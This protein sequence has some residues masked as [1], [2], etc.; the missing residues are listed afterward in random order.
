MKKDKLSL[1]GLEKKKTGIHMIMIYPPI[2][3]CCRADND[4]LCSLFVKSCNLICRRG[5]LDMISE[6]LSNFKRKGWKRLGINS[7]ASFGFFIS[8]LLTTLFTPAD[9][10]C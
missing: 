1:S 2:K 3:T 6:M 5:D 10:Y 8:V 7:T 4:E 9:S